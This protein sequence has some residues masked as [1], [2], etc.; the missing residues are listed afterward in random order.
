MKATSSHTLHNNFK[1]IFFFIKRKFKN[2]RRLNTLQDFSKM[3]KIKRNDFFSIK[4]IFREGT[5]KKFKINKSDRSR[6]SSNNFHL[7]FIKAN[8][9]IS[10]KLGKN[11][12]GI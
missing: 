6:I 9:D 10:N 5:G 7:I 2:I 8:I 12:N 11:E 4:I 3:R 1:L